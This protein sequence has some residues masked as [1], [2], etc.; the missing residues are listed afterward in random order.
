[1]VRAL[2]FEAESLGF[3]A[4]RV[5]FEAESLGLRVEVGTL[6]REAKHHDVLVEAL[7]LSVR[8]L[9]NRV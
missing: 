2:G 4:E 3:D 7:G 8:G 9:G 1:M 5:G 6:Q